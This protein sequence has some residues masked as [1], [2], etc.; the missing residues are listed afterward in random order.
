MWDLKTL[1][2]LNQER[3]DYLRAQRLKKEEASYGTID[4]CA[5]VSSDIINKTVEEAQDED[6]F[7]K[8]NLPK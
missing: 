6:D 5:K 7:I 4:I 1:K 8:N 2:R 3:V